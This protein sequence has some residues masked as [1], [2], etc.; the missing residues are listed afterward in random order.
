[1]RFMYLEEKF[2]LD[3]RRFSFKFIEKCYSMIFKSNYKE[4]IKLNQIIIN[5]LKFG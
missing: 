4:E 3:R 5:Y 1:M 2:N